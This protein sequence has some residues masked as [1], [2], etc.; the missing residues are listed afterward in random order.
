MVHRSFH[1]RQPS[2]T[3]TPSH[4]CSPERRR[5]LGLGA[6]TTLA[7]G[8]LS[9]TSEQPIRPPVESAVTPGR[10][11][12]LEQSAH[13]PTGLL[14]RGLVS[15]S[16]VVVW[17]GSDLCG[18][19]PHGAEF[20][21]GK[22]NW[23]PLP[24]SGAPTL[25]TLHS[26]VGDERFFFVWGG[27]DDGT[28]AVQ[29]NGAGFDSETRRWNAISADGAPSARAE[30]QAIFTGGKMY[31]WGGRT[32]DFELL[33][34]GAIWDPATDSWSPMASEGAPG[35]RIRG[36]S[37]WTGS[38]WFV[39]GGERPASGR[40]V[41]LADGAV[42]DPVRDEWKR[43]PLEGAPAARWNPAAVW[44]GEEVIVWGGLGCERSAEGHPLPCGDGARYSPST[45]AWTP[46]TGR[47]A[48]SPRT[49]HSAVWSGS[50]LVVWGGARDSCPEW[51]CAD[52][53]AYDPEANTWAPI[54]LE[55]APAPRAGHLAFWLGSR[56]LIWSGEGPH[57]L[58]QEDGAFWLPDSPPPPKRR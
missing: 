44:T 17:G 1:A 40:S 56:M 11:R 34:D 52:G 24:E 5:R 12:T 21:V 28:L 27:L 42:Y 20:E 36:A 46:M 33:V 19:C 9:C 43:L 53:A 41:A 16:G 48:P 7:F 30:H 25:R 29:R 55:N 6:A 35:P 23:R 32:D 38:E 58:P 31:V 15:G 4:T 2:M 3:S 50:H 39:W 13:A 54:A 14:Q 37:V 57:G 26:L 22:L 51:Y 8:A 10:W 47:A 45:Q 49:G 18:G